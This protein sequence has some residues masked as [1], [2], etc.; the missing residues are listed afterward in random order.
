MTMMYVVCLVGLFCSVV[1]MWKARY[2]VQ[3]NYALPFSHFTKAQEDV[4]ITSTTWNN[5]LNLWITGTSFGGLETQLLYCLILFV[6]MLVVAVIFA[7]WAL[8]KL[9]KVAVSRKRNL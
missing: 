4:C 9:A 3:N 8:M 2:L 6:V 1:L 7:I 5:L